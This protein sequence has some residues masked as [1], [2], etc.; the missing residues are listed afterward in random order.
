MAVTLLPMPGVG[1]PIRIARTTV[2]PAG[3][4]PQRL[5][6]GRIT[7]DHLPRVNPGKLVAGSFPKKTAAFLDLPLDARVAILFAQASQLLALGG[8]RAA[9][10]LHAIR[11]RVLDP[12]A[13]R[14]LRQAQIAG[15]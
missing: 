10:V 3:R 15:G 14:R 7:K 5:A 11:P 9:L 8:R 2:A 12:V 4:H 1:R 6:H 13:E